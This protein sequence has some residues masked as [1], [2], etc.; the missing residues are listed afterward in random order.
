MSPTTAIE[1][2]RRLRTRPRD[3]R[4]YPI[5]YIAMLDAGKRPHFTINDQRRTAEVIQKR[6]CA[7]CGKPLERGGPDAGAWFTGGAIC[8]IHPNGAF[9]DPPSH[10]ECGEYAVRVCPFLAAPHYGR[11]IEHRTLGDN[12]LAPDMALVRD[13]SVRT[14]RPP[15]FGFGQ[16]ATFSAVPGGSP[17]STYLV[18]DGWLQ[19]EWWRHGRRLAEDDPELLAILA[20]VR[21]E[22]AI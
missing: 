9:L 5:P 4:G 2:P 14:A 11:R 22:A 3:P 7:L 15:L 12:A 20:Q 18:A 10:R 6:G 8:F 13:D 16:T 1:L 21:Q 17:G 19:V